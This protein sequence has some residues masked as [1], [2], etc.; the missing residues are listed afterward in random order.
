M[1]VEPTDLR[2]YFSGDPAL[3]F[4]LLEL[5]PG[6]PDLLRVISEALT[7]F[8]DGD[9][10]IN[11]QVTGPLSDISG[12]VFIGEGTH[13]HAGV[14]ISGSVY[15]GKN[16]SIRHGAQL[17]DGTILGD[18]CVVG[19]DAEIKNSLCM[20][21]SK[22]QNGVFIGDSILGLS[23]RVGSGTIL[24]NRR[25]DQSVITLG[26]GEVKM[27]TQ[28]QFFGAIV[29]DHARLGANVVASPGTLVGPYTWVSSLVS[30]YGFIPRAKLVLLKQELDIRDKEELQLRSGQGEYE[31]L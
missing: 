26:S 3:P 18:N 29:G 27:P 30:L 22:L 25:F 9:T 4:R 13:I 6:L 2:Y 19:H 11:G 20:S 16:C 14:S 7:Q 5:A 21:G 23:A 17:R 28:A 24:S 15:L 8:L 10:T 31:H 12:P 1:A